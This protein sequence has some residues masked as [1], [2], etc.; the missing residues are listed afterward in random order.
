MIQDGT[1]EGG[2]ELSEAKSRQVYLILRDRILSNALAPDARL[3]NEIDLARVHQVSRVTVRRALAELARERLIERRRSVGTR[4]TYQPASAPI[5]GDI[6][7]VLANLAEMGKRTTSSLLSFRYIQATPV[8]ALALGVEPQERIQRSVR[9]RSIDG[10]PFSHLTAHVPNHIGTTYTKS[11]LA[12]RPL[13]ELI[14]RA[15]AKIARASQRISAVLATPETARALRAGIGSPLIELVRVVYDCDGHA[16]EHLRALYRPD[17]YYL[18]M[19]LLRSG[20]ASA[21]TWSPLGG[22]PIRSNGISPK[23]ASKRSTRHGK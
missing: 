22:P 16:V 3:P 9:V 2:T 20:K 6:A 8:M 1:I 11:E 15:G 10:M 13:L 4:V 17:R 18:T 14:E 21:R 5:V 12:R 7:G 23:A 19:D